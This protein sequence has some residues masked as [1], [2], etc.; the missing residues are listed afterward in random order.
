MKKLFIC[1]C[2]CSACFAAHK[3]V[4]L[5][6]DIFVL[7]KTQALSHRGVWWTL[8]LLMSPCTATKSE[9]GSFFL[10]TAFCGCTTTAKTKWFQLNARG[11]YDFWCMVGG[12]KTALL[13]TS[14]QKQ[15]ACSVLALLKHPFVQSTVA[16]TSVQSCMSS[17]AALLL[18]ADLLSNWAD[19]RTRKIKNVLT[20][21]ASYWTLSQ[22]S[23]FLWF[24]FLL[25]PFC[26]LNVQFYQ[27][28][29][30]VIR[31]FGHHWQYTFFIAFCSLMLSPWTAS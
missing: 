23:K 26:K 12:L 28:T 7:W 10:Q 21:L 9:S 4:N 24:Y 16:Q 29:V 17:E 20:K 13:V 15:D 25:L 18:A 8:Q 1:D 30:T 5:N 27:H 19:N 14:D 11:A 2:Q 22:P 3:I 31:K 6:Q